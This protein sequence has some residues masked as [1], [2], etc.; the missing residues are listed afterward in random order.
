[1]SR[2]QFCRNRTTSHE[3]SAH[4]RRLLHRDFSLGVFGRHGSA[5]SGGSIFRP[6]Q[7]RKSFYRCGEIE[8]AA[9]SQDLCFRLEPLL[10]SLG[11]G[12]FPDKD[13]P[14]NISLGDFSLRVVSAKNAVPPSRA[15]LVASSLQQKAGS[16]RDVTVSPAVGVGYETGTYTDPSTGTRQ[17]SSGVYASTNVGVGIGSSGDQ[18]GSTE[19]DRK[20][21]EL[22]LGE[23]GLR[24]GTASAPVA[25]HLYFSMAKKKNAQYQLEYTVDGKKVVLPLPD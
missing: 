5:L 10:R 1:L 23:K 9:G 4:I 2:K 17:H 16:D 8:P 14:A 13:H 21:M 25:G 7:Q 24:E 22:E 20:T 18:P 3:T 6:R 19:A 15:K 11:S 12:Y